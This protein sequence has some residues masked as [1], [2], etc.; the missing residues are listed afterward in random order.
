[1]SVRE[2]IRNKYKKPTAAPKRKADPSI[3][4]KSLELKIKYLPIESL[5]PATY[6]PREM[7]EDAMEKLKRGLQEFGFVDP[8]VLNKDMTIIGG[9][10]R[11]HAAKA[12]GMVTVP[13]VTLDVNKQQEKALNI[14][15]NKISG[16]FVTDMLAGLLRELYDAGTDMDLTG[17]T[18][19]ELAELIGLD[20]DEEERGEED[21]VVEPVPDPIVQ[22]GDLWICG[23]HR[24]LCGDSTNADDVDRLMGGDHADMVWTDPPYNV[25]Y[26][27]KAGK[28]DNDN[29]THEAFKQFLKDTFASMQTALK[30]GG[31]FYIAHAEGNNIGNIFRQSIA[32]THGLM[33]KQCIVWVKNAPNLG[34]ADYN[35]KHEPILYGW[36]EGQA[37][38]FNGDF[39]QTTVIDDDPDVSKLDKKQLLA[40]IKELRNAIPTSVIREDKPAKSPLHPTQKPVALVERN[41]KASSLENQAVLDLFG[42][43]GTTMIACHKHN[44]QARLMEYDPRYAEAILKRFQ[45][46]SKKEPMLVNQDGTLTPYRE[47][48]EARKKT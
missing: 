38:Y 9:H 7:S 3:P 17:F 30:P 8:V 11:W 31:C 39:T 4:A 36:K 19:A 29:M 1:M 10:Q 48:I 20:D 28:I 47:I 44:R 14:A 25:N 16:E 18:D 42:G 12:L 41:I 40:H 45:E 21:P 37:H 27:G 32:E 13:C 23:Q 22:R 46:Y 34:R 2:K 6:N 15:L 5:N 33:M 24:L 43:S 35:W 26:E